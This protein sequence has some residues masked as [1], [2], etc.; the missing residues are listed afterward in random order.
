MQE[1]ITPTP[2]RAIESEL[3]KH[4][5]AIANGKQKTAAGK[6][7]AGIE[8]PFISA[9]VF[10]GKEAGI[11]AKLFAN[12]E[13]QI[14]AG[15]KTA[16]QY[17]QTIK[18]EVKENPEVVSYLLRKIDSSITEDKLNELLQGAANALNIAI[19]AVN[20]TL[21]DTIKAIQAHASEIVPASI[22]HNNFFTGLFNV[23]GV[24]VSP[25]TPWG[26]VVTFGVYIYNT[27]IKPKA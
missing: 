4:G 15:L 6:I 25:G 17:V 27:Y 24:L 8:K 20:P 11:V 2:G 19:E 7:I 10:V 1:E 12:E 3:N 18:T 9:A 5:A 13:P 16:S 21:V 26:K 14:Q 23:L 22:A